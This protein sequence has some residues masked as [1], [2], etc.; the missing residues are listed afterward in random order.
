MAVEVNMAVQ[1]TMLRD[2]VS[3]AGVASPG[4][5]RRVGHT[6]SAGC[7][8]HTGSPLSLLQVMS[9][10]P[11]RSTLGWCGATV[12]LHLIYVTKLARNP[13]WCGENYT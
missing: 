13:G 6:D 1:Q 9:G 4:D 8:G 5:A 2:A 11:E 10:G 12:S 3:K 7:E